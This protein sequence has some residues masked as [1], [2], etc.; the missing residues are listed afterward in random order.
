VLD[1]LRDELDALGFTRFDIQLPGEDSAVAPLEGALNQSRPA[2]A[3]A[4]YAGATYIQHN[5]HVEQ[6]FIDYFER[7]AAEY[8]GKSESSSA[9]SP[10][11]TM[12]SCTV[13]RSGLAIKSTQASISSALTR[14]ARSSST[15]TFYRS[16]PKHPL[17]RTEC[18]SKLTHTAH[19]GH[20]SLSA[21]HRLLLQGGAVDQQQFINFVRERGLAVLA[22]RGADGAPQAALVGITA[23]G[24]GELVFDTSRSSRK[25]RNLSAL[26]T[27]R[28]SSAGTTR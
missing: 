15:G 13:A 12:W 25:Y 24:R 26:L 7:M 22:T 23:T 2:E 27:S 14:R 20:P 9:H 1:G 8:P 11:A 4:T 17:T 16:S 6:A 21:T 18:L 28:W 3:I 10:R 5:P 19:L